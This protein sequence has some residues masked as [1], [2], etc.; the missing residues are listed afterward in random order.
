[1]KKKIAALVTA[2]AAVLSIT[3]MAQTVPES[4]P[5]VINEAGAVVINE[6]GSKAVLS[7][8]DETGKL[9]YSNIYYKNDNGNIEMNIPSEYRD[10]KKRVYLIDSKRFLDVEAEQNV[11]EATPM[12]SE[13]VKPTQSPSP[14]KKPSQSKPSIYEKEADSIYAPALVKDVETRADS[15]GEDIYA[16]TVFYHGKEMTIGIEEDLTISSAPQEY[17]FMRGKS[18]DSLQKG[19]VICMTANIAGDTVRTV[20]FIFRPTEEDIATGDADFGESFESLLSANGLVADKWSVMKYGSASSSDRYEY[21]FGIIGKKDENTLTLINKSGDEDTALEIDIQDDTIVYACNVDGKEYDVE[22]TDV[23]GI[24]TT[25]P[26][27]MFDDGPVDLNDD[28]SYNYALVRLVDKTATEV[29][30]Y[31]NYNE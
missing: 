22:I 11:P 21:A 13:T 1:M 3:A 17:D 27:S 6:A 12:P 14:T 10:L 9:V 28:Y 24:E 7:C 5:A 16:V 26:K 30:L 20:D 15:N 23:N 31:N 8:Y 4:M 2:I 19:D 29:I 25:I 18:M